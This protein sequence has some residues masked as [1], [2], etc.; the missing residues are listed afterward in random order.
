MRSDKPKR[1]QSC[2]WETI[3]V[4]TEK[5]WPNIVWSRRPPLRFIVASLARAGGG[6]SGLSCQR[7]RVG[8]AHTGRYAAILP[9]TAR[10][11]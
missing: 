2:V 9:R 11:A 1:R 8:A 3:S 4:P 10:S 7:G 6:M 5:G